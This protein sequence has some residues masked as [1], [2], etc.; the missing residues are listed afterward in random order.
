MNNLNNEIYQAILFSKLKELDDQMLGK[1]ESRDEINRI[2][3]LKNF[4]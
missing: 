3:Q 2:N 4:I 1:L